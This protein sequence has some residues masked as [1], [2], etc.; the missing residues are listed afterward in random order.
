MRHVSSLIRVLLAAVVGVGLGGC[1]SN[2]ADQGAV[3]ARRS[4]AEQVGPLPRATLTPQRIA[5]E[6][7]GS[8]REAF[9]RYW[10]NL[11]YG[12][13]AMAVDAYD[14]PLRRAIGAH[15]LTEALKAQAALYRTTR[16][17]ID[18]VRRGGA[19][20]TVLFHIT[21]GGQTKTWSSSWRR[22]GGRWRL[23][24]DPLLDDPLRSSAQA[25]AQTAINPA[26]QQPAPRAVQAGYRASQLQSRYVESLLKRIDGRG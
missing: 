15:T 12:A 10:S 2:D 24:Y 23:I 5:R 3:V 7:T 1:G 8:A 9:L 26:A 4:I 6:P 16:P 21:D 20:T 13:W 11:Q 14:P 19:I 18:G 17:A 22:T 25:A